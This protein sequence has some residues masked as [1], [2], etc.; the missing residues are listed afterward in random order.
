MTVV[1]RWDWCIIITS[2]EEEIISDQEAMGEMLL[3]GK[4]EILSTLRIASIILDNTYR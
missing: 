1:E 4:Y 3:V 2:G